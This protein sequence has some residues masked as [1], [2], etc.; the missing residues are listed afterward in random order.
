MLIKP[1]TD[2]QTPRHFLEDEAD[3]ETPNLIP[4]LSIEY[5]GT[6]ATTLIICPQTVK[7]I[8]ETIGG[9]KCGEIFIKYPEIPKIVSDSVEDEYDEDEQLY[10]AIMEKSLKDK[11]TEF[12]IPILVH[13]N[14]LTVVV[15]HQTNAVAINALSDKLVEFFS[16]KI[17]N[18]ITLAPCQLN[19][20]QTL[21][22]FS[23]GSESELVNSIPTVQPPHFI[24]GIGASVTSTLALTEGV[25]LVSLI[26][27]AEGQP[28]YEKIDPDSIIDASHVVAELIGLERDAFIKRVSL[29]VRKFNSYSTSGMYI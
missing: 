16:S 10:S 29:S 23:I 26:L 13:Q 24:T 8:T 19:N 15:P 28:G 21:N 12:T 1:W 18:W 3:N 17:T 22:K 4:H 9:T 25:R 5:A 6:S 14:S 7:V 2:T 11:F 27:N 20:N